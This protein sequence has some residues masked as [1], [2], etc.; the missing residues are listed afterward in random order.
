MTGLDCAGQRAH[1]DTSEILLH[2]HLIFYLFF[3]C[4]TAVW[5]AEEQSDWRHFQILH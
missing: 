4:V 5:G 1:F 3:V 2:V